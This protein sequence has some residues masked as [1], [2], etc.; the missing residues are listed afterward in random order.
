MSWRFTDGFDE[1][2]W[3]GHVIRE[4]RDAVSTIVLSRPRAH[5]AMTES[6]YAELEAAL[7]WV[8]SDRSSKALVLR[9]AGDGAFSAG[10]DARCICGMRTA[11]KG[12]RYEQRITALLTRIER[13]PIPVLAAACDVR[14]RP[15]PR[16]SVCR[17]QNDIIKP[18]MP[19]EI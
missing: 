9:G 12:R 18:F 4:R 5:N 7:T 3:H 8:E 10:T 15:A 16:D 17:W 6:M 1:C 14:S 13:L 11:E 19:V 2:D